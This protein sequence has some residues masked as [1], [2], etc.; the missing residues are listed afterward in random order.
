MAIAGPY[1]K[2]VVLAILK[3]AA[4]NLLGQTRDVFNLFQLPLE[5]SVLSTV[6]KH[7]G[8]FKMTF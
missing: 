7:S 5:I 6:S 1:N 2:V 4:S 8:F 3:K